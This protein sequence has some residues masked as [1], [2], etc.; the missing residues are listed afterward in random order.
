MNFIK[1][2]S[3]DRILQLTRQY[4]EK[5]NVVDID[6]E[7]GPVIDVYVTEHL[8]GADLLKESPLKTNE[9]KIRWEMELIKKDYFCWKAARSLREFGRDMEILVLDIVSSGIG[10][11]REPPSRRRI[12]YFQNVFRDC[13]ACAEYI[14]LRGKE[15]EDFIYDLSAVL[16]FDTKK[17]ETQEE[18]EKIGLYMDELRR[19]IDDDTYFETE[20]RE[21]VLIRSLRKQAFDEKYFPELNEKENF[22]E[23]FVY[24]LEKTK[25]TR[26]AMKKKYGI[27]ESTSNGWTKGRREPPEYAQRWI[28]EEMK[29]EYR[30]RM[31]RDE[32]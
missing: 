17:C 7:E 30:K 14:E 15:G 10:S 24:L 5:H 29:Y 19:I 3:E 8:L 6:S 4:M 12:E 21:D 27:P 11:F 20:D 22:Q 1:D 16:Y 32:A 28:L 9:E 2:I 25:I 13:A 23:A 31:S 18:R 26:Y